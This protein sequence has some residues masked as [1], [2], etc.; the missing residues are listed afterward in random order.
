MPRGFWSTACSRLGE[1][2]LD[3]SHLRDCFSLHLSWRL[4]IV[5]SRRVGTNDPEFFTDDDKKKE[6]LMV[7]VPLGQR[8]C[9]SLWL[10]EAGPP[11]SNA[12][13]KIQ[14]SFLSTSPTQIMSFTLNITH[15]PLLW[16]EQ[17]IFIYSSLYSSW[18]S[19]LH[20]TEWN[21]CVVTFISMIIGDFPK[22][23]LSL[24]KSCNKG[25]SKAV[26]KRWEPWEEGGDIRPGN[27]SARYMGRL[28]SQ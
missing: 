28:L 17:G 12:L 26:W 20:R 9:I 19:A 18:W 4:E 11:S 13:L 10:F 16:L 3:P 24:H 23:F 5:V 25:E 21:S 1:G 2:S 22:S 15:T 6:V 27:H 8:T 7:L 14:V